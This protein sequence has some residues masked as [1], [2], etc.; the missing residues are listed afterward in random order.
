MRNANAVGTSS[1]P[2]K[3]CSDGCRRQVNTP[4]GRRKRRANKV[5]K[6]DHWLVHMLGGPEAI[7]R[8]ML[9][10]PSFWFRCRNCEIE[11]QTTRKNAAFCCKACAESYRADEEKLRARLRTAVGR[12]K[13]ASAVRDLQ[14]GAGV[15]GTKGLCGPDNRNL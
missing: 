4:A 1:S 6:I 8:V 3:Y 13:G 14:V 15:V 2:T 9:E 7:K 11:F 5:S 10:K 12:S